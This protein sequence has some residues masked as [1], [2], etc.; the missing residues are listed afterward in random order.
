MSASP[1]DLHDLLRWTGGAQLAGRSEARL[2]GVSIDTRSVQ[3]GQLFVAIRGPN[4]D[5]HR[6]LAQAAEAGAAALLVESEHFDPSRLAPELP[7]V[8]VL[9]SVAALG[10]VAAAHRARFDGAVVAITGSSGKTTTKEMC[11]AVL[12]VAGPCLKTEGNL[13]NEFGLPL[14]LLRREDRH[15]RVVVEVGMNHRGEIAKL[16]AI[17]RPTIAAVTNV[18]IAHIEFLGSQDEIGHEKGDLYASL[19]PDGVAVVNRDDPRVCSEAAAKAPGACVGFGLS[20]ADV[21]ASNVRFEDGGFSFTLATPEGRAPVH[22]AGLGD[23]TVI[24]ALAAAAVG[25]AARV[26]LG[27]IVT[28]LGRY[29]PPK[30][31]MAQRRLESGATVIDDSYNANPQSLHAA[32][33]S[34]A[35][36]AEKGRSVAVVGDMGELGELAESA[37]Q[38]AGK[39]VAEL[40]IDFL[41]AFGERA[42]CVADA[43][44][45]AGMDAAHIHTGSD[46][47][48]V[49]HR[50]REILGP[51]DWVL[52]KGS[53]AMKME[54]IIE[55]L[56]AGDPE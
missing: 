55:S 19:G 38:D 34:L 21:H 5:S 39:W 1:F 42:G 26:P 50:V 15:Q 16:A 37:H 4:H 11:A 51:E 41:F 29:E 12:S 48:E 7:V 25:V 17:A 54:K 47:A 24:N 31:R 46:H 20:D 49:G 32:L 56:E 14:T 3:P 27:E 35:R 10:A 30:G 22:V 18:G 23:T 53:R 52:V 43:A 6:Y 13:N 28:G 9:D 44:R 2:T 40:G 33:Q 8:G 36:L 45:A